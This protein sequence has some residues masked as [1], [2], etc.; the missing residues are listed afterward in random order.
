MATSQAA[1]RRQQG[2]PV[3]HPSMKIL[4]RSELLRANESGRTELQN[5]Y[6]KYKAALQQLASKIGDVEQEAE[7]HKS[8]PHHP[9]SSIHPALP[10]GDAAF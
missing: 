1:A 5:Q 7:E 9:T 10:L 4:E 2:M 3:P 6:S 8:V